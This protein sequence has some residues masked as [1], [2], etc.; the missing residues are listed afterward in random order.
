M[1][2]WTDAQRAA[3]TNFWTAKFDAGS[4]PGVLEIYSAANEL[5][6]VFTL[7]DP[8]FGSADTD[9][10]ASAASLPKTT[11]GEATGVASY[12]VGK[13][14]SGVQCCRGNCATSPGAGVIAVLDNLNIAEE[15]NLSL[16]AFTWATP[17]T[18]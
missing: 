2:T 5:L 6:A 7:S 10:D 18:S 15:Q 16:T 14:S 12:A 1:A 3:S 9:G 8:A 4:G 13:D 11:T 17:G